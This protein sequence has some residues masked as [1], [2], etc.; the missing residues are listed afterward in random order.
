M[1]Q[2]WHKASLYTKHV[3][4]HDYDSSGLLENEGVAPQGSL[5]HKQIPYNWPAVQ[6]WCVSSV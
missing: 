1:Q 2:A 3:R 4:K 5:L 6:Q